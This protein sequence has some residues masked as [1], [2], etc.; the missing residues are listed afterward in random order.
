MTSH[1]FC[2]DKFKL[3][4][5]ALRWWHF[6]LAAP[7]NCQL[8]SL[9][10]ALLGRWN[11]CTTCSHNVSKVAELK[12]TGSVEVLSQWLPLPVLSCHVSLVSVLPSSPSFVYWRNAG[13]CAA[14]QFTSSS[15]ILSLFRPVCFSLFLIQV[16]QCCL[17]LHW[18]YLHDL[19]FISLLTC[20]QR[21]HNTLPRPWN[22]IEPQNASVHRGCHQP[23]T[24]RKLDDLDRRTSQSRDQRTPS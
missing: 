20:L 14:A 1:D 18:F 17:L 3:C 9:V 21:R 7:A 13:H 23:R 5:C 6:C 19:H 11:H 22:K 4:P 24:W 12:P 16:V 10:P 2:L 8:S 15:I